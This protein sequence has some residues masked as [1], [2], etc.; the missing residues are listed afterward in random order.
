MQAICTYVVECVAGA[1]R[2][3]LSGPRDGYDT[4][5][6]EIEFMNRAFAPILQAMGIEL[7]ERADVDTLASRLLSAFQL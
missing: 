4:T 2:V 6:T 5:A 7:R 3:D 1:S